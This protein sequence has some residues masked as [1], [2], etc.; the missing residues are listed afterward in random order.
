MVIEESAFNSNLLSNLDL[1]L[2]EKL[3]VIEDAA[4]ANNS[5]AFLNLS[6][7][8]FI[9][10]IGKLAFGYNNISSF[11]LPTNLAYSTYG[12]KDDNAKIF[13]GG[14]QVT[15][16]ETYYYIPIPHII[17]DEEVEVVDGY[18]Q[19]CNYDY[20]LID[21]IIPSILDGQVV[22]GIA[23]KSSPEEGIFSGK[24]IMS[25]VFPSTLEV[26]GNYSFYGNSIKKLDLSPCINL[27]HIGEYSFAY[28]YMDSLNVSGCISLMSIKNFSFYFN[29]IHKLDLSC[30][31]ILDTIGNSAFYNNSLT[32]LNLNCVSLE[33]IGHS[34][35]S[36]NDLTSLDLSS[37]QNLKII[38]KRSFY[39]NRI[40]DLNLNGCIGL[41]SI[42][43]ESFGLN[44]LANVNL[45][46]CIALEFI[47]QGA[48]H[49]N[50]WVTPNSIRLPINIDYSIYGWKDLFGNIYA[51]GDLI[52][53]RETFYYIPIPYT[54]TDEDVSIINGMIYSCTYNFQYKNIIIPDTIDNQ[55]VIG[56]VDKE[57]D[58]VFASK[59]ILSIVFPPNLISIGDNAFTKNQINSLNLSG[60]SML[61]RIGRHAFSYNIITDID[62]SGC[63]SID[64]I[65]DHSFRENL[66]DTI[67]FNECHALKSIGPW[68][69]ALN[70]LKSVNFNECYNLLEIGYA[71]FI[72]N[73]ILSLN[74]NGCFSLT[75]IGDNS[76]YSNQIVQLDFSSCSSLMNIENSAFSSNNIE[77]I[78]F[79]NCISLDS[80]GQF[81][82]YNN[83]LTGVNLNHCISLNTIDD[84]AFC[85]NS[86]TNVELN[87]CHSL[88][89]I[90]D[91]AFSENPLSSFLLPTLDLP[92]Y[93]LLNWVDG[94]GNSYLGG[95]EVSNINTFYNAVLSVCYEVEFHV[96]YGND[97]IEGAIVKLGNYDPRITDNQGDAVFSKVIPAT[98]L[99][100]TIS[101]PGYE[102]YN[103]MIS[104]VDTDLFDTVMLVRLSVDTVYSLTFWITDGFEP[105]AG[106]LVSL[107]G[108]SSL[109]SDVSG[110]VIFDS[111]LSANDI[112]YT[113]NVSGYEPISGLVTIID[114]SVVVEVSLSKITGTESYLDYEVKIYPNPVQ[115]VLFI[116]A[117]D[118]ISVSLRDATSRVVYKQNFF[119]NKSLIPFKEFKNGTYFIIINTGSLIITRKIVKI[120]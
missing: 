14:E 111:V 112:E 67:N 100:L 24:G 62:F 44:D 71:S 65:A 5:I 89:I 59:G 93:T 8:S 85:L 98:E 15:N 26:I 21:I 49:T 87:K 82:F 31:N 94:F 88:M 97:P 106:A 29:R 116:E 52:N 95:E 72:Y 73:E 120:Y 51:G 61:K 33:F 84:C 13:Y 54:L 58:G 60:L 4:F 64:T 114:S 110:V 86:I 77:N 75:R 43:D 18:I 83:H 30:C 41:K 80:I 104:I 40:T 45:N 103:S 17:A 23:D 113:I 102:E 20:Q 74:L 81:A 50:I 115:D 46:A 79:S 28:N 10:Y 53:N 47:G 101:K 32:D 119:E 6:G 55:L 107:E 56:I 90:G 78:T 109:I 16:F 70:K 39:K 35:F 2:C 91:Y 36:Y 11:I 19:F 68:A 96:Y 108:Y 117:E 9:Q 34:A 92:G 25:I 22:I 12:W 48:F 63:S 1:S 105:L 27:S 37:C 57:E 76:F 66:I 38:D 42:D 118:I 7:C 3:K 69:F 99:A